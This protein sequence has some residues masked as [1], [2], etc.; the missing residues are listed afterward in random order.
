M[1]GGRT[2]ERRAAAAPWPSSSGPSSWTRA[3]ARRPRPRAAVP[4]AQPRRRSGPAG[5]GERVALEED[6]RGPGESQGDGARASG[7]ESRRRSAIC[8]GRA[9]PRCARC[10]PRPR[11]WWRRIG[12][13]WAVWGI[14][15]L[16]RA[17]AR[18]SSLLREREGEQQQQHS[19]P[20]GKARS[21]TTVNDLRDFGGGR[22]I[23]AALVVVE[24]ASAAETRR[25]RWRTSPSP[26]FCCFL[27]AAVRPSMEKSSAKRAPTRTVSG[28]RYL[29][30]STR[31][32]RH[33]LL[34]LTRGGTSPTVVPRPPARPLPDGEPPRAVRTNTHARCPCAMPFDSIYPPWIHPDARAPMRFISRRRYA[35]TL[36]GAPH[37]S[38]HQHLH[39][40]DSL[41]AN[42]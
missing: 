1:S 16:R 8:D 7:G 26:I 20:L 28:P 33:A 29:S 35:A 3:R 11:R 42:L 22:A 18:E 10:T 41:S 27:P 6:H 32:A 40:G 5:L 31:E 25:Q 21:R 24:I 14:R 12:V 2:R 37:P 38:V 30:R 4:L 19:L 23:G 34:G 36:R 13:S 9:A 15:W 39:P 17:P